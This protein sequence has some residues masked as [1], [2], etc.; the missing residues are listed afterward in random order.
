[1]QMGFPR[2]SGFDQEKKTEQI[3]NEVNER[4]QDIGKDSV[5]TKKIGEFIKKRFLI[6]L[7]INPY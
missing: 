6:F 7:F 3:S 1:M 4:I 2:F 5:P